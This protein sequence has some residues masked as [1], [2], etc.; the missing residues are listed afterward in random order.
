M[1]CDRFEVLFWGLRDLKRVQFLPVTSFTLNFD[2]CQ[3]YVTMSKNNIF[4]PIM[5]LP[6]FFVSRLTDQGWM[7][8][9]V[10]MSFRLE[11]KFHVIQVG[12]QISCHSGLKPIILNSN[13][14]KMYLVNYIWCISSKEIMSGVLKLQQILNLSQSSVILKAKNIFDI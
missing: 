2:F 6:I 14:Q 10:G 8:S 1:I 4:T 12:I 11:F 13:I 7:W 9:V 3:N 5:V